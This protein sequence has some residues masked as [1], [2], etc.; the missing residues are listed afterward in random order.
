M[1]GNFAYIASIT[2]ERSVSFLRIVLIF[3]CPRKIIAFWKGCG[4]GCFR[5]VA[6][7]GASGGGRRE[8]AVIFH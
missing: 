1:L 3:T 8:N 2:R 4:R 5:E 6:G 7:G